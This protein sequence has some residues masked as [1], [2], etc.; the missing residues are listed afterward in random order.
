MY[1]LIAKMTAVPGQRERLIAVL[2]RGTV[3]MPGCFSYLAA[4]DLAD[5]NTIWVTEVWD[6]MASHDAA[7]TLP[8]VK[9]TIAQVKPMVAAF[10]KIATTNPVGGIGIPA[11]NVQ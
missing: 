8:S 4:E 2:V 11:A 6:T 7:L 3:A 1:G 9:D 10:E 5:E